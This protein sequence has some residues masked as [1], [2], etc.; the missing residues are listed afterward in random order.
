MN[1]IEAVWANTLDAL[2]IAT[3]A[4][5]DLADWRTPASGGTW[6]DGSP[7]SFGAA[8][9]SQGEK[10]WVQSVALDALRKMAALMN[11]GSPE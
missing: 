5:G 7:L 8:W 9:G 6:S 3:K 11:N 4:L 1:E 2:A 10:Q